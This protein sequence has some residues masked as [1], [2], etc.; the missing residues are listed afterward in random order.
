M[1]AARNLAIRVAMM[2]FPALFDRFCAAML[3]PETPDATILRYRAMASAIRLEAHQVARLGERRELLV[4]VCNGSSKL[5]AQAS[6]AREQIVSFHF[7]GE[8]AMIP[9]DGPHSYSLQALAP[10][11]LLAFPAQEFMELAKSQPEVMGQLVDRSLEL[12]RR[13]REKSVALGRKTAQER[14]AGFLFAMANRIGVRQGRGCAMRLPMSRRDIADSLGLT[15][16]TVS[17]QIAEL[18]DRGLI[19]TSGRSMVIIPDL[20]SLQDLAGYQADAQRAAA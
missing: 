14:I 4:F 15:N 10:C 17:R 13:S 9:A 5:V 7:A 3:P 18:K 2:T 8:L 6:Q 19:E 11:E 20:K 1:N 16:E 12:L